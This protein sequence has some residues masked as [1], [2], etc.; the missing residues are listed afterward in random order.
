MWYQGPKS[1]F[2]SLMDNFSS[3]V[4]S[5]ERFTSLFCNVKW[6]S[7][8]VFFVYQISFLISSIN[9]VLDCHFLEGGYFFL[10]C[11]SVEPTGTDAMINL[12]CLLMEVFIIFQRVWFVS[13]KDY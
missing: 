13:Y 11:R 5:S 8:F 10:W 4:E 1:K 12:L 7:I 2:L 3:S 6:G 9:L